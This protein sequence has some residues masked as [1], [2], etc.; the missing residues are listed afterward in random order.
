MN[1]VVQ[2]SGAHAPNCSVTDCDGVQTKHTAS[3]THVY[4]GKV[5]I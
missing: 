2:R 3:A 5:E 1:V 4:L